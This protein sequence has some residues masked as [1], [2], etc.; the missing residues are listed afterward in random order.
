MTSTESGR[1]GENPE[2][3]F[4]DNRQIGLIAQEVEKVLP[5]VVYKDRKGIYSISYDQLVPVLIEA[6]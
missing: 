3:N 4:S 2:L 5:E 6:L 1:K